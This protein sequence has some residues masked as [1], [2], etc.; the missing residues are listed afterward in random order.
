MAPLSLDHLVGDRDQRGRDGEAERRAVNG[1]TIKSNLV[2]CSTGFG[3]LA[4]FEDAAD[5]DAGVT[6][7]LR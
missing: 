2:D 6:V 1:L 5:I 3:R 7:R 4:A